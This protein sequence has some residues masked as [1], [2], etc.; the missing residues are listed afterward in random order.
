MSFVKVP[1]IPQKRVATVIVDGRIAVSLEKGFY[2]NRIEIIKT[3]Y[4]SELYKAVSYHPDIV[5][6]H[7]GDKRI[8]YAPGADGHVL[9]GI[10]G[11]GFEL[12][13]GSSVLTS[14]YPGDICYNVARV[15]RF[16]FHNTKYTDKVIC[17]YLEE[18]GVMLVHVN[19]G[20]SKCSVSV[21]DENSIITMDK[22]IAAAAERKGLDVL[23]VEEE[24]ILLPGLDKGFIGGS[25][26]LID[27]MTWAITGNI[28]TLKCSREIKD[29]LKHK[30]MEV[31]CLSKDFVVD[32]GSV[33]TLLEI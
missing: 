26:F 31:I 14:Q 5:F 30:G 2:E 32:I 21:V 7:I 18:D 33:I 28:E 29:F 4:H 13:I 6:H 15:G 11:M 19:Q 16:A 20:Y 27:R 23:F 24:N 9:K 22:G 10:C 12:I 8:I 17:R 1:N 25:S 3:G